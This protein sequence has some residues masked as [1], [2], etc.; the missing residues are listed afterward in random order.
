[1]MCM[2]PSL[3]A[4]VE[5]TV[6]TLCKNVLLF[7]NLSILTKFYHWALIYTNKAVFIPQSI[8]YVQCKISEW[9]AC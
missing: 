5:M 2:E 8:I 4:V 6:R 3:L 9:I 7:R 1:M